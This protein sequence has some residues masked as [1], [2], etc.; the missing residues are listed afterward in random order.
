[1][2]S[3]SSAGA[4][5]NAGRVQNLWEARQGVPPGCAMREWGAEKAQGLAVNSCGQMRAALLGVKR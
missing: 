1:M 4:G 2:E 5:S 3:D